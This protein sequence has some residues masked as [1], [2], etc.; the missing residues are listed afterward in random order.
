MRT[1]PVLIFFPCMVIDVESTLVDQHM[2][3]FA[4]C[5]WK[6]RLR[7]HPRVDKGVRVHDPVFAAFLRVRAVMKLYARRALILML[8]MIGGIEPNPGPIIH[9]P[10]RDSQVRSCFL[11]Y[12]WQRKRLFKI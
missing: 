9:Q 12:F 2:A 5:V 10:T 8:L 3:G 11:F 4:A 1:P 6:V 7:G